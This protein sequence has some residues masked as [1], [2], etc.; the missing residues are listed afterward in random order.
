LCRGGSSSPARGGMIPFRVEYTPR[1]RAILVGKLKQVSFGTRGRLVVGRARPSAERFEVV[2]RGLLRS[3]R[4][5]DCLQ[6]RV[7]RSAASTAAAELGQLECRECVSWSAHAKRHR[8]VP[9]DPGPRWERDPGFVVI[10]EL[11]GASLSILRTASNIRS[12]L[13]KFPACNG[14]SASPALAASIASKPA[15]GKSAASPDDLVQCASP[16]RPR[17]SGA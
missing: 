5:V 14:S 1:Q 12:E 15:A 2:S 8:S 16:A 17:S 13:D 9:Q 10:R 6:V 11:A 7:S 4:A 3:R